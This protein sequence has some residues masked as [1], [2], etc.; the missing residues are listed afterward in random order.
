MKIL[1]SRDEDSYMCHHGDYEYR[2]DEPPMDNYKKEL[3][4][5]IYA[6]E[7]FPHHSKEYLSS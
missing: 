1:S 3:E 7:N 4:N 6:I 5:M 2:R